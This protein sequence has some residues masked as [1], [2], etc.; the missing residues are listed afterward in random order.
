[1]VQKQTLSRAMPEAGVIWV[2]DKKREIKGEIE[3]NVENWE[4]RDTRG[5]AAEGSREKMDMN[6][7]SL[8]H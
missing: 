7:S 1:M 6:C 4:R 3:Y 5:D 8:E 2:V